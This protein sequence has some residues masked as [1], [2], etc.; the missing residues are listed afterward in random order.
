MTGFFV[1]QRIIPPAKTHY[2][3][4]F[5]VFEHNK[6]IDF[7]DNKYMNFKPC[8][9][10]QTEDTSAADIQLEKAHLH[11]NVGNLV[12]VEREGAVWKDLFTNIKYAIDYTHTTAYIN[13]RQVSNWQ[14]SKIKPYDSL[15]LFIGDNDPK[16]LKEGVAK[17]YMMEKEKK[18][19]GCSS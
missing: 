4:G 2:H 6:K 11:D 7:S 10:K 5:V 19:D 13:G 15:V 18:S 1:V 3:A 14:D 8:S 12:H 9:L 16:H 17:A